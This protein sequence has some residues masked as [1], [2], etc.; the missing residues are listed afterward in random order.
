MNGTS[1]CDRIR[2]CRWR[3]GW[4]GDV[5][6]SIA[7]LLLSLA[8]APFDLLPLAVLSPAILFLLWLHAAPRPAFRLGFAYGLGMFGFGV[9][10][11]FVSMYDNGGV[12]L[13]LSLFLTSLFVAF[14]ALFPATLGYL[15]ARLCP[16]E[17]PSAQCIKLALV[18]PAAWV[19]AEWV[20][21]WFL[22]GFPWL[23][24]GYSQIDGPLAGFGPVLGVY[25]IS[26]V[27]A[28]SAGWLAL[29]LLGT[30][31]Q[32]IGAVLGL[33]LVWS[34]GLALQQVS[35]VHATGAPLKVALL[36]GN[37]AQNLKWL[38]DLREPTMA[39]YAQLTRAN[40]DSDLI[41]WPETAVPALYSTVEDFFDELGLEARERG[42][43]LLIGVIHEEPDGRYYNAVVTAGTAAPQFY[44]KRHLVPFTEYLPMKGLLGGL[45][46]FMQ[47]PMSD[48]SAGASAAPLA[49]AGGQQAAVSICYE[50]AFGEETIESLPRA[51]LLVNV[52]NDAWFGDSIAPS[53]HLQIARMRSLETGRPMLRA[54]NTGLTA[55]VD[56]RGRLQSI[57]P[58][59][60]VYALRDSVQP[61]RGMTPYAHV[62]NGPVVAAALLALFAALI[63]LRR[64]RD[65]GEKSLSQ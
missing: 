44:Y 2:D 16:Q 8:F 45:V 49:V 59:F 34:G 37:I 19:L 43:A 20:R 24:L 25:G 22:T 23:H 36:Q 55:V 35:W 30:R 21:G 58:Q 6:A 54:T 60:E 47:V 61:M 63:V 10:W 4:R 38:G 9:S 26:L 29:V 14:L 62:G 46:A 32:R 18:F 27:A 1:P 39:L 48:F 64:R 7:G 33:A 53:Q 15:V 42:S 31:A 17:G 41:V 28:L 12:S 50:D 51:T 5:L 3:Q 57:A 13:G 40:W 52:T 65:V 11:V 56:A